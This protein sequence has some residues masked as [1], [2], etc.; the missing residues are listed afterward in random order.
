MGYEANKGLIAIADEYNDGK[1][2]Y[3][4]LNL[5]W[6]QEG[7]INSTPSQM[8]DIDT[9]TNGKGYLRRTVMP[10]SRSKWEANTGLLT[11]EQVSSFIRFLQK[12]FAIKDGTCAADKRQ[13]KI[14][15][16]NEWEHGYT[17]GHFY[18]PDISFTY[19]TILNEELIYQPIRFAFI[20]L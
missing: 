20:E 6:V 14:R 19:K 3:A 9:H 12:G 4:K 8:Q 16:F 1:Y 2:H 5:N 13:L 11:E 17:E 18:V 15:Y 7:T 10:H